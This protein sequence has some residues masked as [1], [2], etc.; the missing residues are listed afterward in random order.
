VL[1]F[2]LRPHFNAKI[3]NIT[4]PPS[5]YSDM[6]LLNRAQCSIFFSFEVKFTYKEISK[7]HLYVGSY[8]DKHIYL[9]SPG[10]Y[11]GVLS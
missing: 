7:L 9:C 11:Q 6:H 2:P 8:N 10:P 5:K 4:E 1:L 3:G